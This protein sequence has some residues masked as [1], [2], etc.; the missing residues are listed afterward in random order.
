MRV[1]WKYYS[2]DKKT[3]IWSWKR[4]RL[5]GYWEFKYPEE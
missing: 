5:D 2:Y 3:I 4:L 1:V